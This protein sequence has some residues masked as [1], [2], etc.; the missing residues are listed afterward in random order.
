[1]NWNRIR[2]RWHQ[3]VGMAKEQCAQWRGDLPAYVA[4]RRE[5]IVGRVQAHYGMTADDAARV[6]RAWEKRKKQVARAAR[7]P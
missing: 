7:R 2:G 1:M 3:L 5:Q 6:A 4:A